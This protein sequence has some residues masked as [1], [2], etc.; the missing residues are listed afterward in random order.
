M[1]RPSRFYYGRRLRTWVRKAAASAYVFPA[2]AKDD[3]MSVMAAVYVYSR[4]WRVAVIPPLSSVSTREVQLCNGLTKLQNPATSPLTLRGLLIAAPFAYRSNAMIAF[5]LHGRAVCERTGSHFVMSGRRGTVCAYKGL[6]HPL[7]FNQRL[8]AS[9]ELSDPRSES[10]DDRHL[11]QTRKVGKSDGS[12]S[13]LS[14]PSRW[15]SL[16][17]D[18]R[19]VRK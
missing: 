14:P 15:N 4:Q 2:T 5:V 19:L 6:D 7:A 17:P 12:T 3:N 1:P 9:N 11:V 10:L 18:P 16:F 13:C 8:L